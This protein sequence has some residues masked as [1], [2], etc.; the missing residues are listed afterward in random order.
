[1]TCQR[2]D[3]VEGE[4]VVGLTTHTCTM[5]LYMYV[6]LCT[7]IGR[8]PAI[9]SQCAC[10]E[11]SAITTLVTTL[12]GS[13][14][15]NFGLNYSIYGQLPWKQKANT[16]SESLSACSWVCTYLGEITSRVWYVLG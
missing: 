1:M 16:P 2:A 5:Y 13:R 9:A 14:T 6:R 10:A 4:R 3:R 11:E 8:E 7:C 15:I 12:C